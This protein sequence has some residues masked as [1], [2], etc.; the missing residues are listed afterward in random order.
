MPFA[1]L[2]A[3]AGASRQRNAGIARATG[4][5]VVF[6]DDDVD[7]EPDVFGVLAG[8]YADP[9]V[10]GATVRIE[11]PHAGRIGKK[12]SPVR[13]L[14][15]GGGREGSMT[16]YGYPRRLEHV[17]R[18]RVRCHRHGRRLHPLGRADGGRLSQGRA[19]GIAAGAPV[20]NAAR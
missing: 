7:F 9:A 20:S 14:L 1:Y 18:G 16:R 3:E 5:V 8:A 4:D 12:H 13:R 10:V 17:D 15:P 2:A 19:V 6:A 11:E